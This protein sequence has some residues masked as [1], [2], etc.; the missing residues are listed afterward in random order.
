MKGIIVEEDWEKWKNDIVV[1][2]V[3][4]NHF[5]ELKDAEILQNR[6]QTLDNVQQ[7]VGEFFSKE[8]VMKNILQLDDDD[9]KQMKDQIAQEQQS[10][11]IPTDE[12]PEQDQESE[13]IPD[14]QPQ[15]DGALAD[16]ERNRRPN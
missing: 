9:L 3:R 16:Y 14:E 8:W 12:E 13:T 5:T 6:L 15:Q 2:Y 1:D 4:D 7:Y 10:G 11:E